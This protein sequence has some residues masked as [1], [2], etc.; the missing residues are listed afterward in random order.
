MKSSAIHT[1][2]Q[3]VQH[4]SPTTVVV[5][6]DIGKAQH[7]AQATDFRGIVLTKRS[8]AFANTHP[9]F[10][11]LLDYIQRVQRDH[12]L[13]RVV[14]G[15]ESTGHYFW[16]LAQWLLDHDIEVVIVNPATTKRNKENRDNTP[17]KSDPKDALVIADVVSRGYYTPYQPGAAVFERL[18]VLV[19]NRE[20]WV[21]EAGRVKN[22]ITRW[23]DIRFPEYHRVFPNLFG[24]RSLAT[25]RLFPVP[26]DLT[27]L[28]ID[29]V[30][31]AWG[32]RLTRPGGDRGR[33]KATALLQQ[34]RASVGVVLGLEEDRWELTHLLDTYDRLQA[35]IA[36][37][38]QRLQT[39]MDG[40]PYAENLR[41]IG[42]P[43]PTTAAIVAL[44]GD[45]QQYAHGNQLL[46]KAGLNLAERRSGTYVGKVRLSK[47][48][49]A[50]LRKHLFFA[51][52]YLVGQDPGFQALHTHNVQVK[53]MVPMKSVMKLV[54]KLA[55][56][57]VAV[58]RQNTRFEPDKVRRD[59][60]A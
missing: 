12:G 56:I 30:M 16:N 35:I 38:D 48:G 31:Q 15:M 1:Q 25:L 55:R 29:Q 13:D 37:A 46:R 54:G 52:F 20:H 41:S 4:I 44:A 50:L 53:K 34:A 42:I 2:N 45:L 27:G 14:V 28:S 3:R 8:W 32:T 10:E 23:V 18:R 33:R 39:L 51:A 17:S 60:A 49:S 36:E 58:C 43:A 59:V 47:R 11:S 9:G 24:P 5:G 26:A 6:I 40:L 19:R 21:V 57:L 7:V 22:R